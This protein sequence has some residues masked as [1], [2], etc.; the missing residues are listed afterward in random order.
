[1]IIIEAVRTGCWNAIS[2]QRRVV[3]GTECADELQRGDTA[4]ASYVSVTEQDIGRAMVESV[5]PGAGAAFR[6][7]YANADGLDPGERDLLALAYSRSDD[8][9]LC[10]SDKA[11]VVAALSL[12]W[13][14]RVISLELLARSVGAR[15]NSELK[16]QYTESTMSAWRTTLQLGRRI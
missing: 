1:M 5:S 15:P 10:S 9:L 11:V 13:L 7:V 16:R 6:L 8:F 2:G 14:D 12:G 3:T 4:R